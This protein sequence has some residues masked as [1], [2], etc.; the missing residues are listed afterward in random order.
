MASVLGLINISRLE[1]NEETK[2]LYLNMMEKSIHKLDNF[3]NEIINYSRNSRIEVSQEE[4]DIDIIVKETMEG[5]KFLEGYTELEKKVYIEQKAPF[6]SD[7]FRLKIILNNLLSNAI[8]YCS[9]L[10]PDPY[11]II[12]IHIDEKN[13]LIKFTDNGMGIGEESKDKIFNMFYR[14]SEISKGSGIGL[15][16][17]KDAVGALKGKISVQSQL[18]KGTSFMVELPNYVSQEGELL[19]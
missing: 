9:M 8:K 13:A 10:V 14:A 3:I 7:E 12:H 17:V 18:G 1:K 5:L 6:F 4:V 2:T 15:Y 16:I 11:V 19:L